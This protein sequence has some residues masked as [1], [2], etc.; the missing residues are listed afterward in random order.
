MPPAPLAR[1]G[2]RVAVCPSS[3]LGGGNRRAPAGPEP[4]AMARAPAGGQTADAQQCPQGQHPVQRLQA[5]AT[6][7]G[8]PARRTDTR[9][10]AAGLRVGRAIR[11]QDRGGARLAAPGG[12]GRVRGPLPAPVVRR[13]LAWFFA[14]F[15]LIG[16]Y[17]VRRSQLEA[18]PASAVVVRFAGVAALTWA[19]GLVTDPGPRHE[20]AVRARC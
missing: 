20:Q 6:W 4:T 3:G 8:V 7:Q 5:D 15:L 19:G 11:A 18:R 2:G 1:S 16:Q 10:M 17:A 13:Q 14:P 12:T 9:D